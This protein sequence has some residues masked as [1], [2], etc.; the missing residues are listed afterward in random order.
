MDA[1]EKS[2]HGERPPVTPAV[3][4][5]VIR[6][7]LADQSMTVAQ[8]LV[9]IAV[10]GQVNFQTGEAWASYRQLMDLLGVGPHRVKDALSREAGSAIGRYLAIAGSN[11]RGAVK[12]V[13][14][15][16]TVVALEKASATTVVAPDV[17]SATTVV[18]PDGEALPQRQRYHSGS[19]TTVVALDDVN[20]V[21][22]T[23]NALPQRQRY[24]SGSDTNTPPFIKGGGELGEKEQ[25]MLYTI[26]VDFWSAKHEP[27]Q[28]TADQA[29][30]KF[31]A[32]IGR[33]MFTEDDLAAWV[34]AHPSHDFRDYDAVKEVAAK[35]KRDRKDKQQAGAGARAEAE[36]A[37]ALAER[38]RLDRQVAEQAEVKRRAAEL[39]DGLSDADLADLKDQAIETAQSDAE[40]A[41]FA[42]ADPRKSFWLRHSMVAILDRRA[43]VGA[44]RMEATA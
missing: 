31:A 41:A 14:S 2:Q 13:L 22:A 6:G 28:F 26:A 20:G 15:A 5:A 24:H 3:A 35:A 16:T 23:E 37:A 32:A 4:L 44:G 11:G 9:T 17:P 21:G 27:K 1:T 8:R 34:E 43:A 7:V 18:A 10:V 38:E 25:A 40:G 12:Y 42:R 36:R 19:A 33:G 39:L 30:A 29:L